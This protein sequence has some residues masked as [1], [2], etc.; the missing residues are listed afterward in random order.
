MTLLGRKALAAAGEK[1]D[2]STSSQ[3]ESCGPSA[4]QGKQGSACM[5]FES[6][7]IDAG[8]RLAVVHSACRLGPIYVFAAL[9]SLKFFQG[10]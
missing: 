10:D 1:A 4:W 6:V 9:V 7:S 5:T 2:C 3:K 8:L